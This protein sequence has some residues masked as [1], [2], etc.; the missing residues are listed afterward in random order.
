MAARYGARPGFF[1]GLVLLLCSSVA[2]SATAPVGTT[3][4]VFKVDEAGAAT[5]SV[6]IVVPPGTAGVEPKLSLGYNSHLG[7]SIAGMGWLLNGLS[8][9]HRCPTTIAQDGV[10]GDAN[11][12][13]CLDGQRLIA[14]SGAYG[15]NGTE[16]RTERE[17]FTRVISYGDQGDAPLY[18]K[19]WTKSGQILE[20][21]V[22]DDARIE[23][24]VSTT[25]AAQIWALNKISDRLGNYFTATY[26]DDGLNG[27]YYPTQIT[28]TGNATTGL[29]PQQSVRFVYATRPDIVPMYDN[30]S[31]P[32]QQTVRLTNIQTYAGATLVRDYRLAYDQG[33]AT[34]RSRLT[35][36][37]GCAGDG[38]CLP[39]TR[40]GWLDSPPGQWTT[41]ANDPWPGSPNAGWEPADVNGDGR[42][43]LVST[44]YLNPGL[45]VNTLIS[46]GDGTW[47]PKTQDVYPDFTANLYTCKPM[48]VNGDGRADVVCVKTTNVGYGAPD[49][50]IYTLI[51]NS[52]GT[53]TP[54]PKAVWVGNNYDL[55]WKAGDANGDG[56]MD[57]IRVTPVSGVYKLYQM[58]VNTML[59]NGD[60]TWTLQNYMTPPA[61]GLGLIS[62][63]SNMEAAD[64]NGDG[65]I[66]LIWQFFD[67]NYTY[68]TRYHWVF[69]LFS[70]GDGT[71]AMAYTPTGASSYNGNYYSIPD[72]FAKWKPGDVN[73]DGKTDL[74]YLTQNTPTTL[75][76]QTL[77]SQG[78]GY[79]QYNAQMIPSNVVNSFF[80]GNFKL[81][82]VNG[83]GK[84]DL[85][86]ADYTNSLKEDTRMDSWLSN[87]DGVWKGYASVTLGL[88][89][90]LDSYWSWVWKMADINGDGK[91]DFLG[92]KYLNPGIRITSIFNAGPMPDLLSSVTNGLGAR[93]AIT[94]KPLSDP[95]VY[96]K[97]NTAVYP[98]QDFQGAYYVVASVAV[99]NGVGSDNLASYYYQGAKI[100]LQGRGFLDF[101]SIISKDDTAGLWTTTYYKQDHPYI[102]L[103]YS[104]VRTLAG[105][106]TI[107]SRTDTTWSAQTLTGTTVQYPFASRT[108]EQR[109]DLAAAG[110]GALLATTT[111]DSQ[112]DSYG[113][114]TTSTTTT[115]EA[116]GNFVKTSVNTYTDNPTAWL[117]GRVTRSQITS[118]LPSGATA[119]R[120]SAFAYQANSNLLTSEVIEPDSATLRLTT[121]YGYDAFGNRI[122]TTVS[123][124]NIVSRTSTMS[125]SADGRFALSASNALGHTEARAYDGR[126]GVMTSLTGPNSLTTAWQ[127]DGFGRRILETRADGTQTTTSYSACNTTCPALAAY[128]VTTQSTG[129]PAAISYVDKLGREIRSQGQGFDGRAVYRDTQFDAL[130]R[131]QQTSRPYF[132]GAA[133]LWTRYT[134]DIL[135]RPLTETAPDGSVTRTAYQG[136][137]LTLTNALN[138]ISRRITNSQGQLIQSLDAL[139]GSNTFA[140]DPFGNVTRT[141]GPMGHAI[142]MS[143][144][145][146]GRKTAMTDPDMGS[147]TYTYNTLGELTTQT[148]AKG[149]VVIMGYDK[150]GRLLNR[151]EPEGIGAWSY[152]SAVKGIGKLASVSGPNGYQRVHTY[153]SLG[154]PSRVATTI[155]GVAYTLDSAY[156]SLGRLAA[157]TYPTGFAVK[158]LYNA[159]G[160][161]SEVRNSASNAL[162]WQ[163]NAEDA[164]GKL[165]QQTLGNGLSTVNSYDTLGRVT[166]ISTGVG[167]GSA[168]QYLNYRYDAIG[169]LLERKDANQNLTE[170]FTYDGLN[171]LT[172]SSITGVGTNTYQYDSIG[173]LTYKSDVG[174]YTYGA[175]GTNIAGPHA[176]TRTTLGQIATDYTY[177]ANGNQ[178]SGGGRSIS[179]TSFNVPRQITY[180]EASVSFSYDPEH[181]RVK[182]VSRPYI[183]GPA[184]TTIYLNP[185]WDIGVHYEKVT[186][187]TVTEHKHYIAA[188]KEQIAVHIQKTDTA[189]TPAVTT[190]KVYYFHTD[191]L[192]SI[193]TLTDEA[194]KVTERLSYD[195]WGK[196]RNP[197][198]QS[199]PWGQLTSQITR[200]GYTG[201]EMLDSVGLIHMNGRVYDPRLA[202]FLSA[203][204]HIQ[205]PGNSQSLNRYS[206][207]NNNPLSY[208][209]PSGY[210]LKKL[211]KK[212]KKFIKPI[213][214]IVVAVVLPPLLPAA[215]G[216]VGIGA[217]TGAV[218]GAIVGG[219]KGALIGAITG[220]ISGA[221]GS[222]FPTPGSVENVVAHGVLNGAV[223]ASQGGSFLSGFLSGAAPTA[224]LPQVPNL[225]GNDL[226][227]TVLR[228]VV[229]GGI[230]AGAAALT[231]GDPG[232]AFFTA[233]VSWATN[234][235]AH[236]PQSLPSEGAFTGEQ[237]QVAE[238]RNP[239]NYPI[240]P[241]VQQGLQNFNN[242]IGQDY[243]VVITGGNRSASSNLGAG[244]QSQHVLGNAADIYVPGQSNL[245]T[246]NQ[247]LSSGLF[248][249]IGWYEEGYRGPNGEGP[250]VHV[251]MRPG[252]TPQNPAQWGYDRNGNYGSIPP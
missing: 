213:I 1:I 247:A 69:T 179:Y 50:E 133:I 58:T 34:G 71:W 251:D 155:E 9:I 121:D 142:V 17:S 101:G 109:H 52:D 97:E 215:L 233:G 171:R 177:D 42:M 25:V 20:Y 214:A 78:N 123:G 145:L 112:Y 191:P 223:S 106:T 146:R 59:S 151:T 196:R 160:Y 216:T 181:S 77:L 102:G 152:D 239:N 246:A 79:W 163:A 39:A 28:Y 144:D 208:T 245:Q 242:Y 63:I 162:Y 86:R 107:L 8:A 21:G 108:V 166:A 230:G 54:K 80:P 136:Y 236:Q 72:F 11:A 228:T 14:I 13:Y 134:Y 130:G 235:E 128:F 201:H 46:N 61:T 141:T 110:Q 175:Q 137:T 104:S 37:T 170:T 243:D 164:E 51:A 169:N 105:G 249:G 132:A 53:W 22:T 119:T 68:A 122:S 168:V 98:V 91:A 26:T 183:D 18:F 248:S 234:A 217:V 115:S 40:F 211:F 237:I 189:A 127:Y 24:S 207:V 73:G 38:V 111:T 66:D 83:D 159:Y 113:N 147:W 103:P 44:A 140:Y 202:R 203:D 5:Y 36:L 131:T 117:L 12:R 70:K 129:N 184:S 224:L 32:S 153:D 96:S 219:A 138:Q 186:K 94:H 195:P 156:D 188:G 244:S 29:A 204:P 85:I 135:G 225:G 19:A 30:G 206:Y 35:S 232:L 49:N 231:G 62:D 194:G 157:T 41:R 182:Q 150:L 250:H 218:A 43:D 172:S 47:T 205:D 27:Q 154:R 56:K 173:N 82:D 180:R 158:N 88:V 48:D 187:G 200:H 238:V 23:R 45:R 2:W 99:S 90:D 33:A 116:A 220:G 74:V 221:I 67:G 6:P 143:Y 118:T 190:Q 89:M 252:R 227:G 176:V 229:A 76:T 209:D 4:G 75:F 55:D 7:N 114:P 100:H 81:E 185:R 15:A 178:T 87:G 240:S 165:T 149:Q 212:L 120:T 241:Q 139:N 222:T 226:S 198:G 31:R 192:G 126:F 64:I 60:G 210:F 92:V 95:L 84:A 93:T 125:Y 148:D 16:Y 167:A 197:S 124:P 193:D 174:Y 57:M 199:D 161:L 3:A 10:S 65:K